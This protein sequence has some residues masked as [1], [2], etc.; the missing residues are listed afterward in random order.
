MNRIIKP[1]F[2]KEPGYVHFVIY[3]KFDISLSISDWRFMCDRRWFS[4]NP[5][6]ADVEAEFGICGAREA[7]NN[8]EANEIVQKSVNAYRRFMSID[9]SEACRNLLESNSNLVA[10]L[11]GDG[12]ILIE[13]AGG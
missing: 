3:G 11:D 7:R 1:D 6:L 2:R 5:K 12:N 13:E 4:N 10:R 9:I 8:A